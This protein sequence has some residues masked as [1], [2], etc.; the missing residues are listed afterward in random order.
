MSITRIPRTQPTFEYEGV[1]FGLRKPYVEEVQEVSRLLAEYNRSIRDDVKADVSDGIIE[2]STAT[3]KIA[4]MVEVQKY[5]TQTLCVDASTGE[6]VFG[7]G[8][9][10][11]TSGLNAAGQENINRAPGDF[12]IAA[13]ECYTKPAVDKMN[14]L[15]AATKAEA[16]G[17]EPDPLETTAATTTS[18]SDAAS[19]SSPSS[20]TWT[21]PPSAVGAGTIS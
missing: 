1:T 12:I 5:V 10:D 19:S 17:K 6:P 20:S 13:W 9:F 3:G 21:P 16:E 7:P 18:N 8:P 4:L 14:A 15:Q 11:P 2:Y